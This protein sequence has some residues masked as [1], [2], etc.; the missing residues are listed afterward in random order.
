MPRHDVFGFAFAFKRS[1]LW[2]GAPAVAAGWLCMTLMFFG[3]GPT[4]ARV[5]EPEAFSGNYSFK[6]D[7]GLTVVPL[8][9][10]KWRKIHD[11]IWDHDGTTRHAYAYVPFQKHYLV[12]VRGT[13]I[14]T[15][16][17]VITVNELEGGDGW[18]SISFCDTDE[19]AAK[20]KWHETPYVFPMNEFCMGARYLRFS[21]GL[22]FFGPELLKSVEGRGFSVRRGVFA[23]WVRFYKA[24]KEK[25]IYLDYYFFAD[26][27]SELMS[28]QDARDWAKGMVPRVEAGFDGK[29]LKP[30][31]PADKP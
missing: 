29:T 5:A 8:P 11:T 12:K 10:G 9:D 19:S 26:T 1:M 20:Y 16:L 15:L 2:L 21:K 30:Q 6:N 22:G 7:F 17:R 28:W 24:K 27:Y 25:F 23:T 18:E 3:L 13:K 14:T 31:K 4:M